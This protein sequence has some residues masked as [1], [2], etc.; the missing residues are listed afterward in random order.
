L[1]TAGIVPPPYPT[2]LRIQFAWYGS[3]YNSAGANVTTIVQNVYNSNQPSFVA[4]NTLFGDPQPGVGKSFW[5]DYL[6]P[7]SATLTQRF[8]PGENNTVVFATLT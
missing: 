7:N 5:I 3:A 4:G 6:P 2:F 1:Y 8:Y